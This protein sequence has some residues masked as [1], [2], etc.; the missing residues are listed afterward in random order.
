MRILLVDDDEGIRRL[1]SMVLAMDQWEVVDAG[2]GQEAE[3]LFQQEGPFAGALIDVTLPGGSGIDLAERLQEL[4]LDAGR[5]LL[6]SG[7]GSAIEAPYP[8]L[9][10]PFQLDALREAVAGFRS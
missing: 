9:A 1:V 6:M 4:G 3:A 5:I 2:G 8:V 7:Y 10:K